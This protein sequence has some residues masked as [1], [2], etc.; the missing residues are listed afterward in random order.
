[1][2]Q[3]DRL[4]P[5]ELNTLIKDTAG[6]LRGIGESN[7]AIVARI[8]PP[9]SRSS[10]GLT[11]RSVSVSSESPIDGTLIIPFSASDIARVDRDSLRLFEWNSAEQRY[12]MIPL[13]GV[14]KEADY[15]YGNIAV[16]GVYAIIGLNTNPLVNST[17]SAL[18]SLRWLFEISPS[19]AETLSRG[20]CQLILCTAYG[21]EAREGFDWDRISTLLPRSSPLRELPYRLISPPSGDEN[22]CDFCIH[23]PTNL[24][25][26][27]ILDDLAYGGSAKSGQQTA[28]LSISI[29]LPN[30]AI[31][32]HTAKA[33]VTVVNHGPLGVLECCQSA[34]V[35]QIG[36]QGACLINRH[37]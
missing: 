6:A 30:D 26:F 22:P 20:I 12:T 27:E 29:D 35:G 4:D 1:M 37:P 2:P 5:E 16:P 24:P 10:F 31:A 14:G 11:S 7:T 33:L 19:E 13:S 32:G 36:T 15:V 28:D 25:E 34:K 3:L 8:D 18:Y 17:I 23:L 21:F 9:G